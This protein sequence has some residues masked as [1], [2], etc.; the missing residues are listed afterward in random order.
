MAQ[1]SDKRSQSILTSDGW[2]HTRELHLF[3]TLTPKRVQYKKSASA[4]HARRSPAAAG[5]QAFI[6]LMN[7]L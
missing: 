2:A 7:E 1:A 4:R 5:P 3:T 6:E